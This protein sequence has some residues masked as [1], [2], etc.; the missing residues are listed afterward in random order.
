VET[1]QDSRQQADLVSNLLWLNPPVHGPKDARGDVL[2][3]QIQVRQKCLPVPWPGSFPGSD[4]RDGRKGAGSTLSLH[5]VQ[6]VDQLRKLARSSAIQPEGG[7][8]LGD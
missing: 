4:A 8:I 7:G 2:D 3:G 5:P 6:S 1:G